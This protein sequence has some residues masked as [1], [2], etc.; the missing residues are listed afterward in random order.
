LRALQCCAAMSTTNLP[1]RRNLPSQRSRWP[2]ISLVPLG[3]GA[4][5][6]IYAGVKARRPVW[7]LLGVLWCAIVVAGWVANSV[8]KSGQHGND[9]FA[10]F[11]LILG[12]VG[13]VATS[14]AIRSAYERQMSSE[15]E[16]ATEAAE[17]RLADRHRAL[18]MARRNPALA[19]EVGI[20]RPDARGAADAGLVDVN[21]AGVMALLKLPGVDGDLATQIVETR[22]KVG[23]F[24]SLE[25]CGLTLDMDGGIVEGLRGR[26]VFLPRS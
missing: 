18:E 11:L 10:G 8:S 26:V 24:S 7:I 14:F 1:S 3:F 20:G 17:Q 13:A 4:W 6:P 12:W 25:D 16:Q 5:A 9:D 2:F 23:G 22:E 15:L 21:N 19:R